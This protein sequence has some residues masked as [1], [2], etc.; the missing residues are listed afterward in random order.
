MIVGARVVV[1]W[2]LCWNGV[3]K[4]QLHD[5]L[6]KSEVL[7]LG[8]VIINYPIRVGSLSHRFRGGTKMMMMS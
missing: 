5:V 8:L 2:E 4:R 3:L 1:A 6:F 7:F